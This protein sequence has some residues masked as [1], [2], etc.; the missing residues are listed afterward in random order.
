LA[1]PLSDDQKAAI[2]SLVDRGIT[3][4]CEIGRRLKIGHVAAGRHAEK[5]LREIKGTQPAPEPIRSA[6]PTVDEMAERIAR[7]R[8]LRREKDELLAIAGE[9]SFRA[10][11]EQILRDVAPRFEPLAPEPAPDF[12]E[13]TSSE[14]LLMLLSDWHAF[15]EVKPDRVMGFNEFNGD[16]L[17][18]RVKRLLLTQLSIKR[19][20]ERGAGWSIR[21]AAVA[22]NGDF[23]SGT[24]HELERHSDAANVVHAVFATGM[25]LAA[26]LRDMAPHFE[27]VDVRCT[28]GN[29]GRL[30]DARRMQQK[31]PTRNWDTAIYLYAMAALRDIP[32]IRFDI[33]DSYF[34]K[35]AIEGWNFLQFHG[36]DIKSWN[37]LPYYG[38]DRFGRNMNALY[39]SRAER[40]DYFLVS[41]FHSLGGVSAS[42]GETF[43][44]GSVIGG[45]EFSVG[46]LGRCDRPAQWMFMVHK[47]NGITSRWPLMAEG[48][49][50][51]TP[52]P[53]PQWPV[54]AG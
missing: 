33:P 24:I 20:M 54:A 4:G 8:D 1:A 35:Y 37:S 32:N 9:K 21:N 47:E 25:L 29:H 45:N 52:Y 11:L 46:A 49:E 36:H 12:D 23:V 38:I 3:S 19:R 2:R 30:P 13:D 42:G 51:V 7:T 22:L 15:E 41:H 16:I 14:T 28:S 5:Y 44:N 26:Y 40:I 43:V 6:A 18:E 10:Y 50:R 48:R 39:N 34:I 53:L 31:D 17:C 27:R